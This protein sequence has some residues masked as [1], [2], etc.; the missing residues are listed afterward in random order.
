MRHL[1]RSLLLLASGFTVLTLSL[2][3]ACGSETGPVAPS[4]SGSSADVATPPSSVNGQSP[5]TGTSIVV[6]FLDSQL[7]PE[8]IRVSQGDSV[9]LNLETD[10]PGTFHIHGYDYQQEARVGEV[11]DFQFTADATGRF[12]INFHGVASPDQAESNAAGESTQT[13]DHGAT[14][15][16]PVESPVPIA[17]DFTAE[18]EDGAVHLDISTEGWRWAPEEVNGADSDGAGHAHVYADGVKLG[19]IYG[20]Y[21]YL[22]GLDPGDHELRVALNTNGHSDLTW[23]GQAVESTKTVTIPESP[24][25]GQQPPGGPAETVTSDSPISVDLVVHKDELGGYNLQTSVE[26]FEFAPGANLAHEPGQGFGRLS[27]NGKPLNRVYVPWLNLPSQGEGSH[28]FTV[29]LLNNQGQPYHYN[30]QPVEASVQ[31]VEEPKPEETQAE[32]S[33]AGSDSTAGSGHHGDGSDSSS[34]SGHHAQSGSDN[35]VELEVGYLEVLPR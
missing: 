23:Q 17:V 24:S 21:Y 8:T 32:S 20:P 2:T 22:D 19:R 28:T 14:P 7:S 4:D 12:R 29:A 1:K 5:A 3:A 27:I 11:T 34:G 15:H 6:K 18:L 9:T 31:V 30:G 16:G 25:Q 26:G 33:A 13:A 10:R 35:V